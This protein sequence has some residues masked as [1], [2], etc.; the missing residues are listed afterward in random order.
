MTPPATTNPEVELHR[1]DPL[2]TTVVGPGQMHILNHR[3]DVGVCRDRRVTRN[4]DAQQ[5]VH[6]TVSASPRKLSPNVS[7]ESK[8]RD[9]ARTR[10]NSSNLLSLLKPCNA[11]VHRLTFR[12]SPTLLPTLHSKKTSLRGK[13][14]QCKWYRRCWSA[15]MHNSK[16]ARRSG[17]RRRTTNAVDTSEENIGLC[18]KVG[19]GERGCSGEHVPPGHVSRTAV[20]DGATSTT[21]E[22][23]EDHCSTR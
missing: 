11:T 10:H 21:N 20:T 2:V 18:P 12:A 1:V 6:V 16:C 23:C 5:G 3:N 17:K 22:D 19:P 9:K 4:K 15:G 8:R 13:Q 7:T 14:F